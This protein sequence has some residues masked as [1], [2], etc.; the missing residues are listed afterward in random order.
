MHFKVKLTKAQSLKVQLR[1]LKRSWVYSF[2]KNTL[3]RF[4]VLYKCNKLCQVV[5]FY[6]QAEV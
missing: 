2:K 5:P 1:V 6:Y 3:L 4:K